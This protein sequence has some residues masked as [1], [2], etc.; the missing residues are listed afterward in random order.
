M[1]PTACDRVLTVLTAGGCNSDGADRFFVVAAAAANKASPPSLS[2]LLSPSLL[3][4]WTP[5]QSAVFVAIACTISSYGLFHGCNVG[6][7]A[8][9]SGLYTLYDCGK[10][11]CSESLAKH[12]TT[13]SS[14]LK[15]CSS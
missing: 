9:F 12:P 13:G 10:T 7:S 6:M 4:S 11:T 14:I 2:L 5:V 15:M 1:A 8:V 3:P